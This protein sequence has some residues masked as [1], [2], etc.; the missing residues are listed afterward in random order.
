MGITKRTNQIPLFQSS[1]KR[2]KTKQISASQS[3]ALCFADLW[4]DDDF[5]LF[6]FADLWFDDFV[7]FCFADLYLMIF[8]FCF[9]GLWLM[10]LFCFV[11]LIYS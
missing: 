4:F 3:R 5:A 10:I 11:L 2:K 9:A 8:L 7:L 6:C 1:Q